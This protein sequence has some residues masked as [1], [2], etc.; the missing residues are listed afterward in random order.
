MYLIFSVNAR[1]FCDVTKMSEWSF[2]PPRIRSQACTD[3]IGNQKVSLC[4]SGHVANQTLDGPVGKAV[5]IEYYNS[6][7]SFYTFL[8]EIHVHKHGMHEKEFL[9]YEHWY[10]C[11]NT[12]TL[13]FLQHFQL[14]GTHAHSNTF[15]KSVTAAYIV[16]LDRK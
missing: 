4:W 1:R 16:L 13:G 6:F 2:T 7:D 15:Y 12:V 3:R 8:L 5:D 10:L 14:Q 11:L 9:Q